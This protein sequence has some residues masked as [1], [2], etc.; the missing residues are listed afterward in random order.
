MIVFTLT[1]NLWFIQRCRTSKFRII[2]LNHTLPIRLYGISLH[3]TRIIATHYCGKSSKG[4]P[5]ALVCRQHQ[6]NP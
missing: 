5:E 1:V 3:S 4:I 2:Q 6:A